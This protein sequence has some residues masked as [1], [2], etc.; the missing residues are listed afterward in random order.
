M[1]TELQNLYRQSLQNKPQ[2]DAYFSSRGLTNP[3][4]GYLD[5]LRY[6][7][8]T[9]TSCILM[10]IRNSKGE[11][12]ACEARR[13][14]EKQHYKLTT[15]T[16]KYLIYNIENALRTLD[17]V[18]V[19]EGIMD[20]ESLTQNGINSISPLRASVPAP[21]LHLL[22]T[23]KSIY[24]MLDNDPTGI[25]QTKR[26]LD[27]YATYYPELPV[28]PIDYYSKD[29]NDLLLTGAHGL[30]TIKNQIDYAINP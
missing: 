5:L 27:F 7:G 22:T 15:P 13:T 10:P 14:L 2:A 6:R 8:R 26:I 19:T 3:S 11:L 24:L 25:A 30:H 29:P 16:T 1:I 12:I 4:A 20:C 17:Y 23:F 21:V 18:V 9:L 28:T